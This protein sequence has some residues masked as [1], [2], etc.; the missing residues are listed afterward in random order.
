[1]LSRRPTLS[2]LK[3]LKTSGAAFTAA[4]ARSATV[5]ENFSTSV[6]F[7]EAPPVTLLDD[8]ID[9]GVSS[10]T[11]DFSVDAPAGSPVAPANDELAY[12]AELTQADKI[13]AA[14]QKIDRAIRQF[15]EEELRGRFVAVQVIKR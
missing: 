4:P 5:S 3:S 8:A 14:C 7:D 9:S 15:I 12:V 10:F 2:D 6:R 1:M 11:E 13:E